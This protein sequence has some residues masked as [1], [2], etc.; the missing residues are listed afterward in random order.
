LQNGDATLAN[1]AD[2]DLLDKQA[3]RSIGNKKASHNGR[4]WEDCIRRDLATI[5]LDPYLAGKIVIIKT[6]PPSRTVYIKGKA[7]IIYEKEGPPDWMGVAYGIPVALETKHVGHGPTFGVTMP[8]AKANGN[9]H[10][11]VHLQKI[12]KAAPQALVGYYINW[13]QAGERRFHP[14][15]V[16]SDKYKTRRLDGY[17]VSDLIDLCTRF[18]RKN[19]AT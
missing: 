2:K 4:A 6:D 14:L 7:T 17:I 11:F 8:S 5:A 13:E 1:P 19:P 3:T 18:C 10:Q 16:F 9:L 12:A 15:A